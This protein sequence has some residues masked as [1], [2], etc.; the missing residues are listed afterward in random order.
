MKL[1]GNKFNKLI[2]YLIW[3]SGCLLSVPVLMCVLDPVLSCCC[4]AVLG[5]TD[6]KTTKTMQQRK[7]HELL[8]AKIYTRISPIRE[9]NHGT[10]NI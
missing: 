9:I 2:F 8:G 5:M 4:Y 7:S 1:V 3:S 10:T 6:S